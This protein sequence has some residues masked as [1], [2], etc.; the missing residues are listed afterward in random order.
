[1]RGLRWSYLSIAVNAGIQVGFAAFMARVL[2]PSAFGV[3]AMAGV[4]L[5]YGSQLSQLGV[6]QAIVQRPRL[7]RDDVRAAFTS[8]MLLGVAFMGGFWAAAPLAGELFHNGDVVAATRALS[9]GF[10]ISALA[11]VPL[12]LLRRDL[13]FRPIAIIEIVAYVFGYGTFGLGLAAL[14]AGYW[15]LVAGSLGQ[16]GLSAVLLTAVRRFDARP[17]LAWSRVRP[18][19]SF[20][21]KVTAISLLEVTT[22]S[23]ATLWIGVTMSSGAVGIYN[24]ASYLVSLPSQ[25][26]STGLSR[27][28]MPSFSRVQDDIVRLRRTYLAALTVMAAVA[29]PL[30]WGIA[31]AAPQIVAVVLGQQWTAASPVLALLA[32]AAPFMIMSHFAGTLCDATAT[33]WGKLVMSVVTLGLLAA[34]YALLSPLGLT[35]IAGALLFEE[36]LTQVWYLAIVRRVIDASIWSL[37]KVYRVGLPSGVGA[38]VA[39]AGTAWVGGLTHAPLGVVFALQVVVGAAIMTVFILYGGRG[40]VRLE[41]SRRWRQLSAVGP[42]AV[43]RAKED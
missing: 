12:S 29:L 7:G 37:L 26:I 20:G 28:L 22:G 36:L 43:D 32:T 39:T 13:R 3:V 42:V 31:G 21:A 5:R 1:M 41:L 10:V 17:L 30:G 14:G 38:F 4:V 9:V 34:L 6:G 8:S 33:L 40:E 15:A 27:V 18:L 2:P 25:Y 35:G 16:Q 23:L 11:T 19:Y 24:R